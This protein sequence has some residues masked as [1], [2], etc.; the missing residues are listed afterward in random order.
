MRGGTYTSERGDG[1]C[2]RLKVS[3]ARAP[4]RSAPAQV[5]R[6][7]VSMQAIPVNRLRRPLARVTPD[8]SEPFQP[9]S[10][11]RHRVTVPRRRD[12]RGEV[13][14][15]SNEAR[16]P[17]RKYTKI[18]VIDTIHSILSRSTR[19]STRTQSPASSWRWKFNL[20]IAIRIFP[21]PKSTMAVCHPSAF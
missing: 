10:P 7:P 11:Q 20:L 5:A 9:R 21:N 14:V 4:E 15:G 3:R 8:R 19:P 17:P 1:S 16:T 18:W 2:G 13:I 12:Q 6:E